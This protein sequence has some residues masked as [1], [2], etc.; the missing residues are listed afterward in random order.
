MEAGQ[1]LALA[2]SRKQILFPIALAKAEE[3]NY[4]SAEAWIISHVATSSS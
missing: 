3:N 1:E 4:P 2:Q